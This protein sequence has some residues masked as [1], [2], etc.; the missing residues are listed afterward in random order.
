MNEYLTYAG[1]ALAILFVGLFIPG[2]KLF[3]E[4]MLKMVLE[5]LGFLL[6]SKGSVIIWLVK[7]LVADHARVMR[8]AT[9]ARDE[10]DPTQAIK[11]KQEGY[12]R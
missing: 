7:T 9:V 8:H 2:V 1:V 6:R 11:R 12:D 10:I 3:A 5:G 4:Y